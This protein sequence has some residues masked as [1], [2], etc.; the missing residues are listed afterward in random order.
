MKD[1]TTGVEHRIFVD[2]YS[3]NEVEDK[4]ATETKPGYWINTILR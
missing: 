3:L 1:K 4:P 2:A